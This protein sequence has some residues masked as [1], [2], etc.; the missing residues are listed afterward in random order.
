M[1]WLILIL[2]ILASP[3]IISIVKILIYTLRP[4]SKVKERYNRD[5]KRWGLVT[6]ASKGIGRSLAFELAKRGINVLLM[7]RS[8]DVLASMCAEI[9][10]KHP[11]IR[12]RFLAVDAGEDWHGSL[13]ERIQTFLQDY[14]DISIL[15]NNVG[16]APSSL[17]EI[18]DHSSRDIENLIAINCT[19]TTLLT[20]MLIPILKQQP[21]SWIVNMG[22]SSSVD[23][24]P[25]FSCYSASKGYLTTL[26]LA[27]AAELADYP[28][29]VQVF[30]IGPVAT[31]MTGVEKPNLLFLHPD[32]VANRILNSAAQGPALTPFLVHRL[33]SAFRFCFLW[34]LRLFL[35]KKLRKI[36]HEKKK[37]VQ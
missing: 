35:V 14:P 22:S 23:S 18:V 10:S 21:R 8:S 9:E 37:Q 19:F 28:I 3:M 33:Y 29:D 36:Q 32:A 34:D 30:H 17:D 27:L 13:Q 24:M 1:E 20:R 5:G 12:A 6:G 2:G 7:A 25:Y 26:S 4:A 16:V 11:G 15:I 31:E